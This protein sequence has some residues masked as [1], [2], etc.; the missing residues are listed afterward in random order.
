M[1]KWFITPSGLQH[2]TQFGSNILEG[3]WSQSTAYL[4]G[5]KKKVWEVLKQFSLFCMLL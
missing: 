5:G 4:T 1:F 3:V 2:I